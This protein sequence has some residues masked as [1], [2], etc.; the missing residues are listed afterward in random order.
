MGL[1]YF[2]VV[3]TFSQDGVDPPQGQRHRQADPPSAASALVG[4]GNEV[5]A[6]L[7]KLTGAEFA[8]RLFCRNIAPGPTHQRPG[9]PIVIPL[10]SMDTSARGGGAWRPRSARAG[11]GATV[12]PL[13]SRSDF[14]VTGIFGCVGSLMALLNSA[15]LRVWWVVSLFLSPSASLGTESKLARSPL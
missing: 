4:L 6:F 14:G 13:H 9:P 7:H 15:G 2:R 1:V 8:L 12:D 10:S 11:R 5:A 3:F